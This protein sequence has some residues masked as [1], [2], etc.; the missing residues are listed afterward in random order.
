MD[1]DALSGV[2]AYRHT[3]PHVTTVTASFDRISLARPL[4]E[5][6]DLELSGQV[7]HVGKSSMEISLQVAKASG[8]HTGEVL[9]SCAC[10][11]VSLDPATRK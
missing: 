6:C 1:L 4:D 10:T 9:L 3:G 5:L 7:M 11:M 8:E 2:I